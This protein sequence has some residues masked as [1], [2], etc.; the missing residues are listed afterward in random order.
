MPKAPV[1]VPATAPVKALATA[2]VQPP[3]KALATAPVRP[4]VKALVTAPVQPLAT[5]L[6]LVTALAPVTALVLVTALAQVTALLDTALLDTIP[7]HIIV[8]P[9]CKPSHP[10]WSSLEP[11][12][13]MAP[14]IFSW[15]S[16]NNDSVAFHKLV[17]GEIPLLIW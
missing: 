15:E 12:L 4:P 7:T 16:S 13:F 14:Y 9:S 5:A 10:P 2:P 11:F 17:K 6:A 8:V 3:V 1:S